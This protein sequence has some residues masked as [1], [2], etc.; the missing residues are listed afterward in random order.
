MKINPVISTLCL[1]SLS[2]PCLADT[3]TLKDG[4]SFEGTISS[5]TTDSYTV[6]VQITK[7]I[8]DERKVAKTD[9]AKID[10]EQPDLKAFEAIG[11][12]VPTP[13]LLTV[14][15][16]VAKI[17]A[18]EKFIKDY[19]SS[20]KLKDA[21]AIL[22]T[23][24]A[25]SA[26]VSAGG[27]KLNG[28]VISPA[29]YKVN[30][31]DLDARV[32]ESKI[33]DLVSAEQPL[34]ALRAFSD[35][36]RDYRNTLAYGSLIPLMKQVMQSQVGEAKQALQTLD[37]RLKER[38][39]GLERMAS[40]DRKIT[41]DAIKE[42]TAELDARFKAEKDAKLSWVTTSPFHKASL[43]DFAKFGDSEL[44]RLAAVKTILGVDAGKC[45]RDLY[46]LV[47]SGGTSAAFTSALAAAKAAAV[48]PRYLAPLE[49]AG[50]PAK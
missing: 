31:Y 21:K 40:K 49:A 46:T 5:E 18:V 19:R 1:L 22:E 3:F 35:F 9:V 38:Q 41:E 43:D 42:E 17:T 48:A 24:K 16:Y 2:L 33:R 39:V 50:K 20:N 14:E 44:I 8:K 7:S 34:Q 29:E 10:R 37:A 32:E 45:F 27:T 47:H 12:L 36:D 26:Q 28:K 23:L 30:A 25:E 15:E 6:E 13:D 4:T 11:K